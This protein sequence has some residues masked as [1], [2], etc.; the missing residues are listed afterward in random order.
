MHG[1]RTRIPIDFSNNVEP[2][3]FLHGEAKGGVLGLTRACSNGW[4]RLAVHGR[5]WHHN[6]GVLVADAIGHCW[7]L[8]A[9]LLHAVEAE[10][11]LV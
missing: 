11:V 1:R 10:Q 3:K 9:A 8:G 4:H 2:D 7:L 5:L 6:A